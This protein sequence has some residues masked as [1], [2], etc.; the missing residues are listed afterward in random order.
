MDPIMNSG[1][2]SWAP[3]SEMNLFRVVSWALATLNVGMKVLTVYF[4][5]A[6]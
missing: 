1:L 6:S 3:M 5:Q 2:S 4:G